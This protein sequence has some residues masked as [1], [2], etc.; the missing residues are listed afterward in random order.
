MITSAPMCYTTI[1]LPARSSAS[2]TTMSKFESLLGATESTGTGFRERLRFGHP[3]SPPGPKL[4]EGKKES[5][6]G[7]KE[8]EEEGEGKEEGEEEE[9]K[10]E[11]QTRRLQSG[12]SQ[13]IQDRLFPTSGASSPGSRI[14]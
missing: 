8:E 11:G 1:T 3:F 14:D 5:G 2:H 4:R 7:E 10:E 12:R 9:E 13:K 6:E